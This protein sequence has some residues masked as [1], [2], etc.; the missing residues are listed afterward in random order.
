MVHIF[1]DLKMLILLTI[2][3]GT[4]VIL[5]AL[6][7]D[8]WAQALDHGLLWSDGRPLLGKAKT[9]RGFLVARRAHARDHTRACAG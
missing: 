7:K 4:P 5:R 3:N 6:L 8:R 2:A 9:I 1:D